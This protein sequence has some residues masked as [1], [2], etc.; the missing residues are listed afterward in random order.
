[1]LTAFLANFKMVSIYA[2]MELQ[3]H[4]P[5]R[6]KEDVVADMKVK[7]RKITEKMNALVAEKGC[8]DP[9]VRQ[10]VRRFFVQAKW[11]PGKPYR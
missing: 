4:Y 8:S 9:G 2:S 7:S 11:K 3:K 1:M 5:N 6:S 10:V